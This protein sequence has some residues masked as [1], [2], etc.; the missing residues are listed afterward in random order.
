M[1]EEFVKEINQAERYLSQ[2]NSKEALKHYTKAS[3]IDPD[4]ADSYFGIAEASRGIP[5]IKPEVIIENYMKAIE[6]DKSNP[7]YYTSLGNFYL[8]INRFDDAEKSYNMAA[9]IDE[10]N[11]F[12]YLSD[13]AVEVYVNLMRNIDDESPQSELDNARRKGLIAFIKSMGI[14]IDEAMKLLGEH[15]TDTQ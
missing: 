10:K 15:K 11:S 2:F 14:S 13:F 4:A 6:M 3:Q 9:K 7:L 1:K 5:K 12:L 8:E